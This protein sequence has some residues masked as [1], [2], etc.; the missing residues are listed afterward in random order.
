M[1]LIL[2]TYR[3]I[4]GEPDI[5]EEK[6]LVL[7]RLGSIGFRPNP[8]ISEDHRLARRALS[9]GKTGLNQLAIG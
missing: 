5:L 9:P 4:R 2:E 7:D 3:I 1:G 6:L 8:L